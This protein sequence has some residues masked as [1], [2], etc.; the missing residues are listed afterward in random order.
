MY[1][2]KRTVLFGV[3]CSSLLGGNTFAADKEMSAKKVEHNTKIHQSLHNAIAAVLPHEK[4]SVHHVGNV[5][6]LRGHVSSAEASGK[7]ERLAHEFLGKS[8]HVLNYMQIKHSQQVML[9]VRVGEVKKSVWHALAHRQMNA[10]GADQAMKVIAEPNLVAMSGE[11]A[12]FLAGGEL[13]I[14]V[15]QAEGAVTVSYKPYGVRLGFV[16]FIISPHR[17]RLVVEQELSELNKHHNISVGG[18]SVPSITSRKAKTTVEM[19]PGE[20]MMIAGLVKEDNYHNSRNGT[21]VVISVTP[22]LV[23]PV[24]N[25]DIKLPND[26]HIPSKL[27]TRFMSNIKS[28]KSDDM[29]LEGPIGFIA[30]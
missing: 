9:R 24:H 18:F 17:I 28:S 16:P 4:I 3:L 25:R 19:A 30:E 26:L 7:A 21:E 27:E 22:Y 13:P 12:E 10:I 20:S 1:H 6:V 29:N 5:V 2:I 23:D 14:P 11:R 8:G 15:V